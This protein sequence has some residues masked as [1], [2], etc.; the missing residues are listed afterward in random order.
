MERHR[1]VWQ[2]EVFAK[3]AEFRQRDCF[4]HFPRHPFHRRLS[5][6]LT[7]NP[8]PGDDGCHLQLWARRLNFPQSVR[9]TEMSPHSRHQLRH[10][11]TAELRWNNG[12]LPAQFAKRRD[13]LLLRG[14]GPRLILARRRLTTERGCYFELWRR[15]PVRRIRACGGGVRGSRVVVDFGLQGL[16]MRDSG[17]AR[18][19]VDWV[20]GG[21]LSFRSCHCG[22]APMFGGFWR[23]VTPF[24]R[25]RRERPRVMFLTAAKKMIPERSEL[26]RRDRLRMRRNQR[27]GDSV[28]AEEE[29]WRMRNGR[30]RLHPRAQRK[31]E[32]YAST[33]RAPLAG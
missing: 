25:N 4:G 29:E 19:F 26:K 18:N 28:F 5:Y 24:R 8:R 11:V 6:R 31:W 2:F 30:M 23:E 16:A 7:E 3:W 22:L 17:D 32:E 9:R 20:V 27:R 15:L 21:V 14:F 12:L 13:Q 10:G 1:A 33:G